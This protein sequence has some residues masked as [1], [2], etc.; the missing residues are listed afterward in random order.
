MQFKLSA[1]A[2]LA[3]VAAASP[4]LNTRETTCAADAVTAIN[5][6]TEASHKVGNS[7]S[8]LTVQNSII[9]GQEIIQGT[10]QVV[11]ST[12]AGVGLPCEGELTEAEQQQ[13]CDATSQLIIA[14]EDLLRALAS[15][16]GLLGS[17]PFSAP[18][19]AAGRTLEGT[20]DELLFQIVG[21]TPACG[22]SLDDL[23][24]ALDKD[25]QGLQSALSL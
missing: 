11:R 9:R 15:K 19:A 8:T 2:A 3:S 20:T 5:G 22:K 13:I 23:R 10:V 14:E 12:V 4:V 18:L 21:S 25:F 17:T 6:L 1:I 7:V 24:K 16:G